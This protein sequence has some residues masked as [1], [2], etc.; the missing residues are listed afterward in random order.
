MAF[1]QL[2]QPRQLVRWLPSQPRTVLRFVAGGGLVLLHATHEPLLT[3]GA[4]LTQPLELGLVGTGLSER[5]GPEVPPVL[6]AQ[7]GRWPVMAAPACIFELGEPEAI[8][9]WHNARALPASLRLVLLRCDNQLPGQAAVL[10]SRRVWSPDWNRGDELLRL[11]LEQQYLRTPEEDEG[12]VQHTGR[13]LVASIPAAQ[14]LDHAR[15]RLS[16]PGGDPFGTLSLT[17]ERRLVLTN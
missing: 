1:Y 12:L 15:F 7:L 5:P 10:A 17:D 2:P 14:L 13:K 16:E 11:R 4:W 9:Q 6:C 8:Y 3:A